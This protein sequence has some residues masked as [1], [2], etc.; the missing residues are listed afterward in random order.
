MGKGDGFCKGYKNKFFFANQKK[1][2]KKTQ[3]KIK[4]KKKNQKKK[5]KCKTF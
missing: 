2:Q 4:T 3:E 5:R 1:N